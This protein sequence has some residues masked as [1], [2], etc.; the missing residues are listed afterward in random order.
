MADGFYILVDIKLLISFICQCL[1]GSLYIHVILI[2][3]MYAYTSFTGM[4]LCS[5]VHIIHRAV[6]VLM[7]N[8][9]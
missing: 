7:C 3:G 5:F 2:I 1:Y 9:D 6:V 8:V 4:W